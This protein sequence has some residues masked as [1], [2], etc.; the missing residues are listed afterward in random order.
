MEV[1][2][3]APDEFLLITGSGKGV[4]VRAFDGKSGWNRGFQGTFSLSG[5]EL[6]EAQRATQLQ[7][8]LHLKELYP[9]ARVIGRGRVTRR[10]TYIVSCGGD[11]IEEKFYFDVETGLLLRR[12]TLIQTAL[13]Q[14][15]YQY[16]YSDYRAVDGVKLPFTLRVLVPLGSEVHRYA[17]VEDNTLLDDAKFPRPDRRP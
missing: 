17:T 8:G 10:D 7:P 6:N 5:E 14:Y 13:G 12:L 4:F 1:D 3:K 11:G 16:D 15:P 2:T 9:N